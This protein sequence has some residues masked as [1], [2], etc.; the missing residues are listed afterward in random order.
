MKSKPTESINALVFCQCAARFTATGP[1]EAPADNSERHRSSIHRRDISANVEPLVAIYTR[2]SREDAEEPASTRRQERA[3]REFARRKGWEVAD[4][5]EDVDVSAYDRRVRR[6]AFE[7]LVKV[8]SGARINGVLVWKLDRLVRR[9]ADFERFWERCDR[10]GVFLA[11]ATEPIDSTTKLGLAVIRILVNFA[12][13]ESTSIS[14]RL[15]SRMAEKARAGMPLWNGRAFGF[16]EDATAIVEHEAALI[17]ESATR[18]LAGESI[19][20]IVDDWQRREIPTSRGRSWQRTG[21]IK[22]LTNARLVGDHEF[23]GEIAAR[24]CFPAILDRLVFEQLQATLA[25]AWRPR[26]RAHPYLLSGLLRCARCKARL[27]GCVH[28]R[29]NASGQRTPDHAYRCPSKPTG[30]G[31]LSVTA[32]FVEDLVTEAVISRIE[33]RQRTTPG[34]VVP[35]DA[36]ERLSAAYSRYASSLSELVTDYY[37][38]RKLSRDEWNAARDALEHQLNVARRHFD[39]RWRVSIVRRD[40][41]PVKFRREWNTFDAAHQ[42]DIIASELEYVVVH[43]SDTTSQLDS[44]RVEP[45]WGDDGDGGYPWA[46]KVK[47]RV[48]TLADPNLLRTNEAATILGAEKYQIL[49]RV[50]AGELHPITVRKQYRFRRSEVQKLAKRLSGA[51]GTA[52]LARALGV[53]PSYVTLWIE[54]GQLP[55]FKFAGAYHVRPEDMREFAE[56]LSRLLRPSQAA[57][58]L[59]LSTG[60]VYVLI[61]KGD[62]HVLKKGWTYVD[63]QEVMGLRE[64]RG[65]AAPEPNTVSTTE[66]AVL[67]QCGRATLDR[68]VVE[69]KLTVATDGR[70][71]YRLTPRDLERARTLLTG[72]KPR[73]R[74]GPAHPRRPTQL[75]ST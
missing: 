39:P 36:S 63:R 38:C 33:S 73:G 48:H 57:P 58:L 11:S 19:V 7:D 56:Q 65:A 2:V 28:Y 67:L 61:N 10:S 72:V 74:G 43:R 3:C 64:Q 71:H 14:L 53:S 68:F 16:N 18:V 30:C 32:G 26:N 59:G 12:N 51:L 9:A 70:G 44:A 49:Q 29:R 5:W 31:R 17:R 4:V 69:G 27:V 47:G 13:V 20:S 42:R 21:L 75:V 45:H 34:V 22:L 62:L 50:H 15:R 66:A 25:N 37:V 35:P 40:E 6:P 55:A 23:K 41:R 24:G 54:R 8:V 1:D 52:E 46:S 60:M